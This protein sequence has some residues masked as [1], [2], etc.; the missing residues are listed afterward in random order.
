MAGH[1][2]WAN[3][4]HRKGAQDKKRGKIFTRLIREI[5]VAARMGGPDPAAN[6]RLRLAIDKAR[7]ENLPKDTMERAIKRGAGETD[8][9]VYQEIRYEGYGPGGAAVMVDCLT[10][11]RNRTAADVRH[12][13]SKYGGNLGS[14]GS[15]AYLFNH[16]GVLNYPAGAD[17]NALMEAALEAGADDVVANDDGSIDVLTPPNDFEQVR[18]AMVAAGL[19][20][21]NAEVTMQPTTT[22]EL[23]DDQASTIL[24][25]LEALEDLDDVQDVFSNAD[26]SDEVIARLSG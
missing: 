16:C 1:S 2:K 23:D 17:E 15:V 26:F 24:K 11:N 14:D 22:A 18:D 7:A 3:I 21:E 10:D 5:T 12:A 13:F 8:G 25:L 4:K 19:K 20:P 6:P 9:E